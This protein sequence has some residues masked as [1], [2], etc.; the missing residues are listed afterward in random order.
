MTVIYKKSDATRFY[1]IMEG[2]DVFSSENRY[3][4]DMFYAELKHRLLSEEKPPKPR[5]VKI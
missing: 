2:E 1:V 3:E 4:R 5:E